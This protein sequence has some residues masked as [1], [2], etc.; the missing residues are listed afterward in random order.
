MIPDPDLNWNDDKDGY[1]F[2]KPDWSEFFAVISGNGPCNAERLGA[3]NKAWDD[4]TWFRSGL[5]AYAAKQDT[6]KDAAE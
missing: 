3:R 5:E 2:G 6:L 1:D 4:G